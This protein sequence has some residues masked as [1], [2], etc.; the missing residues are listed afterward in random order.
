M[1]GASSLA[2]ALAR[3]CG[4]QVADFLGAVDMMGDYA[5]MRD[6]AAACH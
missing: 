4:A 5:V 6:Q 2:P 3:F 1:P